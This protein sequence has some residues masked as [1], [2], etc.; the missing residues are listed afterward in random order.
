MANSV[1]LRGG[2][3]NVQDWINLICGVLLFV[4]PW[5]LG[6]SGDHMAARTAW[7]GGAII[8][9][10]G[11]AALM[12]FAEWEE[13][14]ALI[15]GALVIVAPWVLRFEAIHAAMWS[16]VVLG[17]IVALSSIS[18]IWVVHHPAAIAGR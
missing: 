18:E 6:F 11:V 8:F 4:S 12:Q 13:W 3:R 5:G 15:V 10:M 9:I 2:E 7:V 17:V 16:C 1:S 14:V